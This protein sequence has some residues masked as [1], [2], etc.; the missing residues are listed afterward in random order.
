MTPTF[1]LILLQTKPKV[2]PRIA[3]DW[4]A[5]VATGLK[6]SVLRLKPDGRFVSSS[7]TN[8]GKRETLQGTYTVGPVPKEM[9]GKVRAGTS[10][11]RF[12]YDLASLRKAGAPKAEIDALIKKGKTQSLGMQLYFYPE[13]PLLTDIMTAHFVPVKQK[14]AAFKRLATWKPF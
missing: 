6:G 13:V 11:V 8:A 12:F 1:A 5:A 9:A 3:Q 4:T 7:V 2:D 14:A 10:Q